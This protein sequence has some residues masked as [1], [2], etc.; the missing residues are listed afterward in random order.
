M[1]NETNKNRD[2][3]W[4]WTSKSGYYG[5]FTNKM[6]GKPGKPN[7]RQ[8]THF[9]SLS[10]LSSLLKLGSWGFNISSIGS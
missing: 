3:M 1:E 6:W 5:G 10:D 2:G 7:K 4:I 9:S 8:Q